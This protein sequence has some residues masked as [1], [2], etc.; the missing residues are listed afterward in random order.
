MLGVAGR[1]ECLRSDSFT[2]LCDSTITKNI[3]RAFLLGVA[4]ITAYPRA[5]LGALQV[6]NAPVF[7]VRSERLYRCVPGALG[8]AL[9]VH[10][11]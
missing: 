5:W 9:Q 8:K 3:P 4:D 11:R 1:S 7:Q 2:K 10:S 6:R